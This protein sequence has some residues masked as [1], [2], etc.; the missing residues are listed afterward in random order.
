MIHYPGLALLR[1][2][3]QDFF[4]T[5]AVGSSWI[6]KVDVKETEDAFLLYMDVP[7]LEAKDID[8]NMEDHV[9]SI[10]GE[11]QLYQEDK[12]ESHMR[13]ERL[14]GK[15]HRQFSL[16]ESIDPSQISAKVKQG[17]L[18]LLL[19]KIKENKLQRTI[20]VED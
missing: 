20:P 4:P 5:T 14:S 19:P 13:R 18:T 15:F 10:K 6:P 11:R 9:L 3:Q 1:E 7:G 2:L 8:I 16:P 17:V 12:T